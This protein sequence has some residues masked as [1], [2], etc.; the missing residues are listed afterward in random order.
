MRTGWLLAVG[1]LLVASPAT[2]RSAEPGGEDICVS[3]GHA[4]D[5]LP[6]DVANIAAVPVP[7]SFLKL[8]RQTGCARWQLIDESLIDWHLRFGNES[9]TTAALS[10]LSAEYARDGGPND[11]KPDRWL[12]LATSSVRAA[13]LY[14]S[15]ALLERSDLYAARVSAAAVAPGLRALHDQR[16]RRLTLRRAALRALLTRRAAD[17][18]AARELLQ[19]LAS[20]AVESLRYASYKIEICGDAV[21]DPEAV[22]LRD[23]CNM[24]GDFTRDAIAYWEARA[25]I[26]VA[27][28]RPGPCGLGASLAAFDTAIALLSSKVDPDDLRP[29]NPDY[30]SERI[31]ALLLPYAEVASSPACVR[32]DEGS[33]ARQ[34][35]RRAERLTPPAT[36]P[37]QFRMIAENYLALPIE[38]GDRWT[39]AFRISL[40]QLDEIT[41]ATKGLPAR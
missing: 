5:G 2:A 14:R 39:S 26:E 30:W 38:S 12:D 8:I 4:W 28:L 25:R 32:S 7:E 22:Q 16:V 10:F 19:T 35:L 37:S 21:D 9:T 24:D 11:A 41:A 18:V 33:S 13:E 1:L 23:A 17:V 27:G 34:A 36:A 31:V 3:I 6:A 29:G 40:G 15:L 20:P